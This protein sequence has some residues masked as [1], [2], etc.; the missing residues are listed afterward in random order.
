MKVMRL[1]SLY[2]CSEEAGDI[3]ADYNPT[4]IEFGSF[5]VTFPAN[6]SKEHVTTCLSEKYM[7]T[8]TECEGVPGFLAITGFSYPLCSNITSVQNAQ[9]SAFMAANGAGA[10]SKAIECINDA[11]SFCSQDVAFRECPRLIDALRP[12]EFPFS[13]SLVTTHRGSNP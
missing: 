9:L 12:T 3:L 6:V 5:P 11:A 10:G 13:T 4:T 8:T 2:G 7:C 1:K